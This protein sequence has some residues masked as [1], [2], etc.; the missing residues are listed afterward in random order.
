MAHDSLREHILDALEGAGQEGASLKD[1]RALH[2]GA[3]DR[4][5][6]YR[7]GRLREDGLIQLTGQARATRYVMT[8][9]S[10][11][12]ALSRPPAVQNT[13]TPPSALARH[14]HAAAYGVFGER[15][16]RVLARLDV[17]SASRAIARYDPDWLTQLAR[18]PPLSPSERS[19]L[20]ELGATGYEGDV[21]GTY[22]RHINERLLIDLSWASSSLEGNTYSL[23][24]TRELLERGV[25]A[26]GKARVETTMILN[27]KRAIEFL[28]DALGYGLNRMVASNLHATLMEDL[29]QD[30]RD[31][32]AMRTRAVGITMSTY[33][34]LGLPSKIREEFERVLSLARALEDPFDASLFLL[35]A[36][37]YLQPFIDGNKRSARLLA[38]APLFA[39][40]VRPLSFVDV[41]RGDYLRATLCTYEFR[42]P[43]PLK[44]LFVHAYERSCA[45]YPEVIEVLPDPDPFRLAHRAEIYDAARDVLLALQADPR[46]LLE[47][48]ARQRFEDIGDRAK[49]VAI[50]LADLDAIH[51]GNF[52]RYRVS[53]GQFQ[54]Y[55]EHLE[56]MSGS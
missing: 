26:E 47:D 17:P 19:R 23:L 54:A 4:Q 51:D 31:L 42:D 16:R 45:R 9:P 28:M 43:E 44:E 37:P 20:H 48:K 2:P 40:N 50:V 12:P 5:L 14:P 46:P 10:A 8:S 55:R 53:P 1:L 3:T 35:I 32:G 29:L 38:N 7:L 22:I 30:P 11:A 56:A 27:H 15:A 41:D 21:A 18:Q 13:L 39:K 6:R 34:P 36:L 24:D 49:F 52:M 33:I 25:A